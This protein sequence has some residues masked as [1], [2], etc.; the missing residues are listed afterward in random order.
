MINII[1][2]IIII[3][4]YYI[5]I[6]IILLLLYYMI[7][8]LLYYI[9]IIIIYYNI[10]IILLLLILNESLP[11]YNFLHISCSFGTPDLLLLKT[12]NFKIFSSG[13]LIN[14]WTIPIF[15][16]SMVVDSSKFTLL[17]I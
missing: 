6:I 7:I 12:A 15:W 14:G 16:S 4:L 10:I 1:I 2:N 3:W 17:Q 9:I 13:Q 5:I 8:L 11:F